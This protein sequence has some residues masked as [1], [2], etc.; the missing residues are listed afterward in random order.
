MSLHAVLVLPLLAWWL[1]RT[2]RPEADRVRIVARASAVYV[3]LTGAT[4]VAALVLTFA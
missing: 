4:I 1:A 3:A 2:L